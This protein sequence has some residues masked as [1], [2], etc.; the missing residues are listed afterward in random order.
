MPWTT[1]NP[2][3]PAKNWDKEAQEKCTAAA[4]AVLR[5]G[6]WEDA[7]D[8][9]KKKLEQSAIFACISAAGKGKKV[10]EIPAELLLEL[11]EQ[12]PELSDYELME[13][14]LGEGQGVGGPKQGIG[15][16]DI[17]VCPE[18]G[19][20][21]D[22]ERGT[23]CV[24]VECPKCGTAMEGW[25]AATTEEK[26][27][28]DI[29][30]E[31]EIEEK[32]IENKVCLD[33]V[34]DETA[35]ILSKFYS[36]KSSDGSDCWVA[37]SGSSFQDREGEMIARKAID[38]G[39]RH[40]DTTNQRGELRLYHYP[41]SRVG[42]CTFQYRQSNFLI[43][44]GR[45]DD[46]IRAQKVKNWIN[47]MGPHDVG[48][49]VGFFYNPKKFQNSVY[50]DEVIFFERSILKQAHASCPWATVK[51]IQGGL[52]TMSHKKDLVEMLGGDETAEKEVDTI[53]EGAEEASKA[54]EEQ[55][56]AFKETEDK[57]EKVAEKEIS[58][59]GMSE[60]ELKALYAK[61]AALLR[62]EEP[63]EKPE[64]KKKEVETVQTF[65]LDEAAIKAIAEAVKDTLPD[66]SELEAKIKALED[67]AEQ[68]AEELTAQ[69]ETR[70]KEVFEDLPKATIYRA[71]KTQVEEPDVTPQWKN[72]LERTLEDGIRVIE[73]S[74][75]GGRSG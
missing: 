67:S 14:A 47:R 46:T 26:S 8:E 32:I 29:T 34:S 4:N 31:T 21:V 48:V 11:A 9:E 71:T 70:V 57:E 51:T 19:E 33:A 10:K 54:L 12:N 30:E 45:W 61:I 72:P 38:Y 22:H 6:G 42:E 74:R 7:N 18:C 35:P 53:L 73:Q 23:P 2:P 49:S 41:A 16:T 24:E 64:E 60:D 65:Q 50:S 40:G 28:E 20:K 17:C 15:G 69:V 52:T 58:L 13:K 63:E 5:D 1:D 62:K 55:G 3:R 75:L 44:A 66:N 36:F 56:V 43:E 27:A 59:E 39:I 25:E 68:A 37:L